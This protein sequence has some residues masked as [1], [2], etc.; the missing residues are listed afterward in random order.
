M[1]WRS[2][3]GGRRYFYSV[4][5]SNKL[6]AYDSGRFRHHSFSHNDDMERN[7]PIQLLNVSKVAVG[8]EN[9]I[10]QY[11]FGIPDNRH[12]HPV[13]KA[14]EYQRQLEMLHWQLTTAAGSV[15]ER[16]QAHSRLRQVCRRIVEDIDAIAA[17]PDD[18]PYGRLFI[19]NFLGLR[20]CR[21]ESFG[22]F[23]HRQLV[24]LDAPAVLAKLDTV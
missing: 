9:G 10:Q 23:N 19:K 8:S 16:S 2:S 5:D 11:V 24:G 1:S 12:L 3:I 4:Y 20:T 6:R 18:G 14:F 22:K 21:P 7:E 15:S 17:E 13:D